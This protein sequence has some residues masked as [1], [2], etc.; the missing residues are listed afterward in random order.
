MIIVYTVSY[1]YDN[2]FFAELAHKVK[3]WL[4]LYEMLYMKYTSVKNE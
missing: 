3:A 4:E 2:Y 1:I